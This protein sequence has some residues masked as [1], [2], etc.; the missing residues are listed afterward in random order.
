MLLRLGA[1]LGPDELLLAAEKADAAFFR[2]LL[3]RS[4][5]EIRGA[6]DARLLGAALAP[7]RL[8]RRWRS[9]FFVPF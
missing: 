2:L 8:M 4:D 7:L 6:A 5:E 1:T 3:D 9:C